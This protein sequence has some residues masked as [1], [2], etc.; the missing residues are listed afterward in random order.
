M[1]EETAQMK[2]LRITTTLAAALM[3]AVMLSPAAR[4]Q[5]KIEVPWSELGQAL[6]GHTV[7]T[8]LPDGT[9]LRGR[10]IEVCDRE[11][12]FEVKK[13][14]NRSGY[15]KGELSLAK[16]QLTVFSYTEKRGHWRAAG[17]AIGAAGGLAG[18]SPLWGWVLENKPQRVDVDSGAIFVAGV[19]A[20][21]AAL[22]YG[23]GNAADKHEV[24]VIIA[25]D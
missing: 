21:A 2:P 24:T 11:L 20:G 1:R 25:G 3:T 9:A 6:G 22:G 5:K 13:T 14:S 18:T 7:S 16:S 12:R 4:A 17:T 15:P 8:V 19:V 10:A 23:I